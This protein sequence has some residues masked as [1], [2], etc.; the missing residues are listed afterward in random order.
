MSATLPAKA[1]YTTYRGRALAKTVFGFV[2]AGSGDAASAV[3]AEAK[4]QVLDDILQTYFHARGEEFD[5]SEI[6][7]TDVKKAIIYARGKKHT[8]A[9]RK[10]ALSAAKFGLQVAVT[11]GG[12]TVGSVVPVVGTMFGA[13]GGFI[14]GSS[15][16]G[17][18][19]VLDRLKRGA[20]GLYKHC[21]GTRGVHRRQA[22]ETLLNCQGRRHNRADGSNPA[23]EALVVI[24]GDEYDRVTLDHDVDRLAARLASN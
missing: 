10:G 7:P 3:S 21:K 14:A 13:V 9:V 16:T 11:A 15:L 8:K 18:V 2:V 4:A 17:G 23:D 6:G 20:K 22:A 19:M 5:G 12:A 1:P 24:L